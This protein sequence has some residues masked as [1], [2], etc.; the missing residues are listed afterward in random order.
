M[1]FG[2]SSAVALPQSALLTETPIS[3]PVY[4]TLDRLKENVS[5]VVGAPTSLNPTVL[6]L[7]EMGVTSGT[8]ITI[9]R[10]APGGDPIEIRVRGTRLCVRRSDA[11][12]FPVWHS[13]DATTRSER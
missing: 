7:L 4:L 9:T 3:L 10:R 12:C 5:A 2:Q 1:S 6:R 8:E 13:S 11:A